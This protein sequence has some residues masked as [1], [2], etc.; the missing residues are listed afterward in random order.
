MAQEVGDWFSR[1]LSWCEPV[2]QDSSAGL[3]PFQGALLVGHCLSAVLIAY[4][5]SG[6]ERP[7]ES[8]QF[9]KLSEASELFPSQ[10]YKSFPVG[11]NASLQNILYLKE[12]PSK[13]GEFRRKLLYNRLRGKKR[14]LGQGDGE[15]VRGLGRSVTVNGPY[16]QRFSQSLL[17]H[18][19]QFCFIAV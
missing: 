3:F 2:L 1:Q 5:S 11:W 19:V 16:I 9:Q 7:Y 4:I 18:D 15:C 17:G 12:L 8:G 13:M 14:P 6:K 10:V